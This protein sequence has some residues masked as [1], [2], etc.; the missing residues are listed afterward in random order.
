MASFLRL[1]VGPEAQARGRRVCRDVRVARRRR[2]I[3]SRSTHANLLSFCVCSPRA[4][5][6]SFPPSATQARRH[7]WVNARGPTYG[8]PATSV[9]ERSVDRS[10]ELRRNA[11]AR[12]ATGNTVRQ[13]PAT[14]HRHSASNSRR[15]PASLDAVLRRLK[16]RG[17]SQRKRPGYVLRLGG[18]VSARR[19]LYQSKPSIEATRINTPSGTCKA[20]LRPLAKCVAGP[21][22][23]RRSGGSGSVPDLPKSPVQTA[24]NSALCTAQ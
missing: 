12:K 10:R 9:S 22:G 24:T 19:L 15:T 7:S 2:D 3:G 13:S 18:L 17:G 6:R 14:A 16:R 20:D 1:L 23:R 11:H 8:T 4:D 21:G 5:R